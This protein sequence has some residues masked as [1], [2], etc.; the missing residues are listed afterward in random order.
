MRNPSKSSFRAACDTLKEKP[1]ENRKRKRNPVDA[2]AEA[3][4][5]FHGYPPDE[6]IVFESLEHEHT[7]YAGIGELIEL[8]IVPEGETKGVRLLSFGD[9]QLSM[10]ESAVLAKKPISQLYLVGGDQA[11]DHGTLR[12][13]GIDTRNLHEQETLGKCVEITYFTTKTHLG[14]D[15]GEANYYHKLSED[16]AGKNL[17]LRIL[18]S[19]TATYH[20]VNRIIGLW[21]GTYSIAPEGIED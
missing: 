7:V 6:E 12:K 5:A 18:K 1:V 14:E 9:C 20:V 10:N 2:A 11:L 19:P 4:E 8:V 3:F 13:F 21:G 17:Q 15:G 16:T